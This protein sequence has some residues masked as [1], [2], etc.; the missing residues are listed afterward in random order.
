MPGTRENIVEAACVETA[1]KAGWIEIK[2]AKSNR[3]G[4]PD[5][6]FIKNNV[7]VWAEFKAPKKRASRQQLFR[8]RELRAAGATVLI[9]DETDNF[10]WRLTQA[11]LRAVPQSP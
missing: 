11:Y 3:R 8:H 4:W 10:L 5:R 7:Y 9:V 2:I 6:L 1:V